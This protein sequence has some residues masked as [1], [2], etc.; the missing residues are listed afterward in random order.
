MINRIFTSKRH[1][2]REKK[3]WKLKQLDRIEYM[4]HIGKIREYFTGSFT[5]NFNFIFIINIILI[6]FGTLFLIAFKSVAIIQIVPAIL[7]MSVFLLA[8]SL[9]WDIFQYGLK[10]KAIFKLRERFNLN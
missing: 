8:I 7:K 10:V 4:M 6:L 5:E 2:E 9:S 3:F 1:E